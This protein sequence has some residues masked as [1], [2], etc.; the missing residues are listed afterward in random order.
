MSSTN[1]IYVTVTDALCAQDTS[2]ERRA[3]V[4][5]PSST[6]VATFP[7]NCHSQLI[8][9]RK[10]YQL[11][12]LGQMCDCALRYATGELLSNRAESYIDQIS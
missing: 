1:L 3:D 4:F 2:L 12:T 9:S 5:I 10:Q 8:F 6:N 11:T 7:E